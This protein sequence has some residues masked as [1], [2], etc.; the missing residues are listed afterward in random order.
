M[1]TSGNAWDEHREEM[2][3]VL[4]DNQE[5]SLSNKLHEVL[6]FNK[7]V[8][9]QENSLEMIVGLMQF[10]ENGNPQMGAS[11]LNKR[12][13]DRVIGPNTYNKNIPTIDHIYFGETRTP[14]INALRDELVERLRLAKKRPSI[15]EGHAKWFVQ[16]VAKLSPE[17][18]NGIIQIETMRNK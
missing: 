9:E 7:E 4:K 12:T 13:G 2:A 1:S 16:Q 5:D 18:V 15:V 10:D 17:T 6:L 3:R 14:E 8:R 11:I